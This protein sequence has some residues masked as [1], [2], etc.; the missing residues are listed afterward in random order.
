MRGGWL[1]YKCRRC[2]V[3]DQSTH[4][5]DVYAWMLAAM[6]GDMKYLRDYDN[7][8]D[9]SMFSFHSCSLEADKAVIGISD[10]IGATKDDKN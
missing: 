4:V 7:V 9:V 8:L 5:P 3:L 2:G 6:S 10:L 1:I